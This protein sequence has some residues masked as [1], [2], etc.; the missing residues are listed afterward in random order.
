MPKSFKRNKKLIYIIL[1]LIVVLALGKVFLI[2]IKYSPVLFQLVFNKNVELK[3]SNDNINVLLLGIGGGKHEGP[4]LSDTVIFA[5]ISESKN[6]VT[7]I[8]IPRDLWVPDINARVNVAYAQGEEKRQGGGLVLAEAVVSKVVGQPIDYGIRVD[9][10]GFVKAV[11][12][13]G[14][15]DINVE[16]TLD[17]YVYP[18]DGKENDSC[19]KSD[20]DIQVFTDTI[21]TAS[22]T[23]LP[24]EQD[25][26][27]FFPCRY[28][29]VHF[30]KGQ[31][32]INGEQALEFVRSRHATGDEGTDFARSARQQKVI[33]S[34]KDNVLS[35]GTLLNPGKVLGLYDILQ[36]SIDTDIKQTEFDDF[37]R[38]SQK[39]RTANISNA[40]LD[41]G[42]PQK[43]RP[44]ILIN[45][46]PSKDY[47]FAWILIPRIGNGDFSEIK[48]Y[49]DCEI[50]IGNCKITPTSISQ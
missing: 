41:Y 22:A 23:T 14:G 36:S 15:L 48:K 38:L 7:L 24:A 47:N 18:V 19:G 4:N 33:K 9:F 46:T 26:A 50:K 40:V 27:L 5:S 28:K 1:V 32:H 42:D 10:A 34:F 13:V 12:M 6:K 17:D 30:D 20:K 37:I 43:S 16:N 21:A 11:D 44:G 2:G 49:V 35:F 29:H 8:S 31:I 25:L 3:K 45:P 39:M